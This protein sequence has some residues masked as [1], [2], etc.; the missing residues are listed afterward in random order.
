MRRI[1]SRL[2]PCLILVLWAGAPAVAGS[3]PAS[4]PAALPKPGDLVFQERLEKPL[5]AQ[6]WSKTPFATWVPERGST[7]LCV[8][9]PTEEARG[10]HMIERSIDLKPFRGCML[11]FTCQV[12][13]EGVSK[14]P[15][16]YNGVKYM[17]HFTTAATGPHWF[18]QDNVYGSFDW[19]KV[20]FAISI[21]RDA[22]VGTLLLG[23][24]E[25]SGTVWF[26]DAEARVLLVSEPRPA[27]PANPGPVFR[28]HDLP[29]LRGVMS[30][31][32]FREQDLR[33]LGEEWK[34]NLIRWQIQ[35]NWGKP[36]TARDLE[37]Y[38]RWIDGKLDELE[39]VLESCRRHGIR[40]VIDLHT[41]P[42]GRRENN[43]LAIFH[44]R[45]YQ[46][47]FV[48]LWE[49]IARRYKGHSA[50]WGY[51]LINEPT[52]NEPSPEGLCD[53]LGT[54]VR[55]AKAIRAID[56]KTTI[57]IEA[58][59]WD[60]ADGFVY[61]QPVAVPNV[62]YQ[63][64]MYWP[65][66]F[67]HQ[68]VYGSPTG[69]KYP[70]EIDGKMCDKEA[71]R[72]HLQPVRDFQVAY[73]VHIYVGEFSAI[74]WAPGQSAANYLRD[75]IELFEEYGWDWSY[76]AYREWDGWSVEH[77]SDPEDKRPTTEPT[78]RKRLLL[79]WFAR[80]RRPSS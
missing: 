65:H 37:E 35:R 76:H 20:G 45:T 31:T 25:S 13:A 66:Q 50:V 28:G 68:G 61:L 62:V 36:G 52:Q 11:Y 42:G 79:E 73:N 53:Y 4:S 80:N 27:P 64:H 22:T 6:V 49:K 72:K 17:L 24:Q 47:H 60:S 23:L 9:V 51:D 71:L 26:D 30:P 59:I 32:E 67:T 63:V 40:V 70:G 57:F 3:P 1:L 58:A 12:K 7:T 48:A 34:A 41:P 16:T 21:P 29:R 78:D 39:R 2:I 19:K 74:R 10:S 15:Q 56:P 5:A 69:V 55:A 46:E 14:P 77:G 75:C 18:N 54:Q 33:V 8:R 44:E 38:D 43:D